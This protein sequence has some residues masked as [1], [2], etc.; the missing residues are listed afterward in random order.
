MAGRAVGGV[1][2]PQPCLGVRG[3]G[4][5]RHPGR[6]PRGCPSRPA[7]FVSPVHP[8]T[9]DRGRPGRRPRR[10]LDRNCLT[11]ADLDK[12]VVSDIARELARRLDGEPFAATTAG[13]ISDQR[14]GMHPRSGRGR[15]HPH[16]SVARTIEDPLTPQSDPA[17]ARRGHPVAA[18]P[19]NDGARLGGDRLASA[20]E[21]DVSRHDSSRLLRRPAS[22]GDCDA[23]GAFTG[24]P[25][26]RVGPYRR[27]GGG[28]LV[29]RAG[30]AEDRCSQRADSSS[31][32]LDASCLARRQCFG[33]TSDLIFRTRNGTRPTASNWGRAWHRALDRSDMS[34]CGLRL[35]ARSSHD[36]ASG[37][38]TSGRGCTPAGSQRR[39]PRVDLR[40]RARR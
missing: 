13:A 30:R 39:H 23:S 16:R 9:G 3:P 29:R 26:R 4:A 11:L 15:C 40:W 12:G 10:W 38:R 27:D 18:R 7:R 22:I 20:R 34:R 5:L 6:P 36:L 19:G 25:S 14:A 2:A 1:A 32:R 21:H 8:W 37:R 28:H 17:Q 31:A 35:P 24:P 33:R